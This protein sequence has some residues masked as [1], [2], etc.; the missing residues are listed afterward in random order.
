MRSHETL[1]MTLRYAHL[2]STAAPPRRA[3]ARRW[4]PFRWQ[5]ADAY[6][7]TPAD[8]QVSS[9][10]WR[11]GETP[12]ER[13]WTASSHCKPLVVGGSHRFRPVSPPGEG[14]IALPPARRSYGGET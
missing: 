3:A 2:T 13:R 8:S 9:G 10:N 4:R 14:R 12:D 11:I 7:A 5:Y 1:T 6:Q